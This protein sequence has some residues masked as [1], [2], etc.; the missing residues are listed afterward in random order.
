MADSPAKSTIGVPL[1][2]IVLGGGMLGSLLLFVAEFTTLYEV[3]TPAS[4]GAFRS[5]Q[6]GSNHDYAMLL[7][8]LVAAAFTFG[9][10]RFGS[11]P[12]LLAV[13]V[14]GLIALVISLFGDLPDSGTSGLIRVGGQFQLGS[15]TASAGLY[16]E[17][18][19]AAL[20]VITSVSGFILAG[21]REQS[22]GA[23][24]AQAG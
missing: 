7:I 6:T 15:S 9:A 12:A 19:G 16:M 1:G 10:W 22:A 8:A 18:L 3:H 20:L 21:P 23:A 13:G 24:R 2:A 5:V 11:R 14:L 17:T 4:T